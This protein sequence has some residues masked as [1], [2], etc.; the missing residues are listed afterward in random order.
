MSNAVF[1]AKLAS[2]RASRIQTGMWGSAPVPDTDSTHEIARNYRKACEDKIVDLGPLVMD[3]VDTTDIAVPRSMTM[4]QGTALWDALHGIS[5]DD[6]ATALRVRVVY[7]NASWALIAFYS[8]WMADTTTIIARETSTRA[9][10]TYAID[11]APVGGERYAESIVII[12]KR[13]LVSGLFD[14]LR[15]SRCDWSFASRDLASA[16]RACCGAYAHSPDYFFIRMA[17]M[18]DRLR[19]LSITSVAIRPPESDSLRELRNI[20]CAISNMLA[21]NVVATDLA[22]IQA[23]AAVISNSFDQA[24]RESYTGTRTPVLHHAQRAVPRYYISWNY[25]YLPSIPYGHTRP[26]LCDLS[27]IFRGAAYLDKEYTVYCDYNAAAPCLDDTSFM[28]EIQIQERVY[29]LAG[30]MARRYSASGGATPFTRSMYSTASRNTRPMTLDETIRT[31]SRLD[32]RRGPGTYSSY[33]RVPV[34]PVDP[35]HLTALLPL[36]PETWVPFCAGFD[37]LKASLEPHGH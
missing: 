20:V 29:G 16:I 19:V 13:D 17:N 30:I 8:R 21:Y 18:P 2:N 32:L 11:P 1:S 27:G 22:R 24:F 14:M 23:R 33:I 25:R 4:Q 15:S 31:L 34:D 36:L 10:F 9:L 35:L 5:E 6:H 7:S 37:Q 3:A 28:R 26:I 12:P